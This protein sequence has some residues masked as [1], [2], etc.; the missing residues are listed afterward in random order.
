MDFFAKQD[1]ARQHTWRLVLLLL[2]AVMA[3][4]TVTD[5]LVT[6]GV[7]LVLE[8]EDLPWLFHPLLVGATIVAIVVCTLWREYQ[9]RG[10]GDAVAKIIGPQQQP[11]P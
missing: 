3:V 11:R 6:V 9:L 7:T 4:I 10:G 2:F 8:D 5:L 1:H